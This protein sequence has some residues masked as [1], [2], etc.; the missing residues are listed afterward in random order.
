MRRA[1]ERWDVGLDEESI[2][3]RIEHIY[4][5]GLGGS[6]IVAV[7][8]LCLCFK[9]GAKARASLHAL[10]AKGWV[11]VKVYVGTYQGG[12]THSPLIDVW[13]AGAPKR[14]PF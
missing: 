12:A 3:R 6:V 7:A 9:D 4:T 13:T 11:W 1:L 8:V 14:K 2:G 10:D 5:S